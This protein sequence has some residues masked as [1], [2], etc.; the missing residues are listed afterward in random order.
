MIKHPVISVLIVAQQ[1]NVPVR[2]FCSYLQ[3][4]KHFSL[5]IKESLPDDLGTFDLIVTAALS[6]LQSMTNSWTSL[7]VKAVAGSPC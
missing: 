7:S 6:S 2:T 4:I 1:Q 5:I 3:T